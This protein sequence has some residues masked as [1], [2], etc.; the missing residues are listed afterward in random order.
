MLICKKCGNYLNFHSSAYVAIYN[1]ISKHEKGY[2]VSI[3]E[4]AQETGEPVCTECEGK[5]TVVDQDIVFFSEELQSVLY[6]KICNCILE[7]NTMAKVK[8]EVNK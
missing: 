8:E 7:K 2:E 3:E 5:D 1:I 6:D 4:E